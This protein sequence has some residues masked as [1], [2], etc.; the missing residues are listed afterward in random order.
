MR[1]EMAEMAEHILVKS[2]QAPLLR[3]AGSLL[4][5]KYDESWLR[6]LSFYESG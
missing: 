4:K 1:L 2:P 5:L 6:I 3:A